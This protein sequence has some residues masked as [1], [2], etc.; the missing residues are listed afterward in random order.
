[1]GLED[2]PIANTE[3]HFFFFKKCFSVIINIVIKVLTFVM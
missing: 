2:F 3:I 1:M